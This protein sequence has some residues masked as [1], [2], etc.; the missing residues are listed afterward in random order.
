MYEL[1]FDNFL[2]LIR[3]KVMSEKPY[4]LD[5]YDTYEAEAIFGRQLISQDII[6]INRNSKI[7]E[8]GAG[9]LILSCQLAREGYDVTALEPI[10]EGFNHFRELQLLVLEVAKINNHLPNL[11]NIHAES[12]SHHNIYDYAFSINVMEHVRC[13]EAVIKT[14]KFALKKNALYRFICPNYLFPFEPHFEIPTLFSKRLTWLV[15]NKKIINNTKLQDPLGVWH[16]LN[17]I[18]ICS[19]KKIARKLG[20]E[21]ITFRRN[22]LYQMICRSINDPVF[23]KRR[24]PLIL[25]TLQLLVVLKIHKLVKFTPI[26]L[27]PVIDCSIV[28]RSISL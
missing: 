26:I 27:Q 13:V 11:L 23:A 2:K 19:L 10:G 12:L 20:P 24:S 22:L 14:V 7:L 3:Q 15:F 18:S 6:S 9:A 17:W 28:N 25:H 5:I 4:L 16:S 1:D 21:E 8:V